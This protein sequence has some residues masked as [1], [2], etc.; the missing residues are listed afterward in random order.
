MRSSH[1]VVTVV[2]LLLLNFSI[3]AQ[4]ISRCNLAGTYRINVRDSDQLYSTVENAVS[5]VPFGEQQ[6]FFFDLSVRLTPPD[7]LALDCKGNRV[8]IASSRAAKSTFIADGKTRE[9]RTRRGDLISARV[10]LASDTLTFTSNGKTEDRI[11]VTF[12]S[13]DQG[14][15]LRVTRSIYADQ[16]A[17]PVVIRTVYDKITDSVQWDIYDS[18]RLAENP[19]SP[20]PS[21]NGSG[22]VR[23]RQQE[24]D[25]ADTLRTA[26]DDWIAATNKRDI[27]RQMEFY[28]PQLEAFY[29]TRNS[30]RSAVR[31]EKNQAFASANLIDIRAEEP[32]IVF[33]DSGATAVMRFRKAYKVEARKKIKSGIVIQELRWRRTNDG[34]RISSERDV[35]V[36]R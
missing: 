35:R 32:E 34:W 18:R 28:M 23:P 7:M 22:A 10:E 5:G 27:D 13:F 19:Q 31:R 14:R 3:S 36:I 4:A 12:Q 20:K 9:E 29:L 8:N 30:P 15:R 17:N 11:N 16:L 33:Q 6:R 2:I 21:P 1:I 26:L 25:I 24:N